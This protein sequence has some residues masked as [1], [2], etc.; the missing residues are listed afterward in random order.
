MDSPVIV[1]KPSAAQSTQLATLSADTHPQLYE[2]NGQLWVRYT[3]KTTGKTVDSPV[4]ANGTAKAGVTSIDAER[5]YF[6]LVRKNGQLYMRYYDADANKFLEL[7]VTGVDKDPLDP[8]TLDV[9]TKEGDHKVQLAT[10]SDGTVHLKV[11]GK[12]LGVTLKM[13][14]PDGALVYD[15]DKGTWSLLNG[16]VAGLNKA[17]SNGIKISFN[18][19]GYAN[20]APANYANIYRSISASRQGGISLPFF[21]GWE[22]AVLLILVAAIYVVTQ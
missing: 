9:H 4:L 8:S 2:K 16:L 18:G 3:D 22:L 21:D 10:D 17:F 1:Q 11:D 15:P 19:A 13:Q 14:G 5:G 20:M 7:P 12:D 6:Q